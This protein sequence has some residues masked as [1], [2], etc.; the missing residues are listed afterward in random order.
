[1]KT[2]PYNFI[3]VRLC[4]NDFGHLIKQ[5]LEEGVEEFGL[6]QKGCPIM[7][8]KFI[9]IWISSY[10]KK[11]RVL[12]LD[13]DPEDDSTERYLESQM[14]VTFDRNAPKDDHDGGSAC[15]DMNLKTAWTF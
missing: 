4:D 12:W 7:W 5:A 1:M 10:L 2:E 13:P 9:I 3:V 14:K 11:R 8:K 6:D 15:Y